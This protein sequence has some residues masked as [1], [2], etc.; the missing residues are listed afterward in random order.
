MQLFSLP[1]T[2]LAPAP[3]FD[4]H[5]LRSRVSFIC[6]AFS[7][8]LSFVAL[9]AHVTYRQ[10]IVRLSTVSTSFPRSRFLL[11]PPN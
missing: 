3:R 10:T 1:L 8:F 2:L 7:D 11:P 9:S 6:P 5:D 4:S